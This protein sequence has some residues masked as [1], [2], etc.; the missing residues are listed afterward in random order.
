MSFSNSSFGN[1]LQIDG[2]TLQETPVGIA[3]IP[4]NLPIN[5]NIS[6]S[7]ADNIII[8]SN[9][10]LTGDIICNDFTINSGITLT[11]NGYNIYCSGSFINNGIIY[12]G[13]NNNYH[14]ANSGNFNYVNSYG[15]SG[16]GSS[17]IGGGGNTISAGGGNYNG[18]TTPSPPI[19]SNSTIQGF[20]NGGF[21]NYL[22]GAGGGSYSYG[23][24]W[25]VGSYGLY[26]QANNITAGTINANGT[27]GYVPNTNIAYGGGGGGVI[28][29]SYKT[30]YTAGTYNISGGSGS[31]AGGGNVSGGGGNGQVLTFNYSTAPIPI[32]AYPIGSS[33]TKLF[34]SS[35]NLSANLNIK[36]SIVIQ[37]QGNTPQPAII[38]YYIDNSLYQ[39]FISYNGSLTIMS[40]KKLNSGTHT[41]QIQ[42]I[43]TSGTTS[44]TAG[45]S[46]FLIEQIIGNGG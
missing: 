38:Y 40:A 33:L 10:T 36:T 11:T 35:I 43:L 34:Q 17:G 25:A 42:G 22:S 45:L 7:G 16:G 46:A 9:T 39:T 27:N 44:C 20:Y 23:Y 18:G 1:T 12:C 5:Y 30:S 28:L 6:T 26:I 37:I 41:F 8:N 24:N 32:N 29:L 15:G 2:I 4:N 14:V 19:L 3:V 13:N 31:N 21:S